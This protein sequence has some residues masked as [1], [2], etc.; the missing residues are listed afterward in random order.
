MPPMPA[1]PPVAP[2]VPGGIPPQTPPSAGGDVS[3]EERKVLLDLIAKV[4]AR[5][6]DVQANT[7]AAKASMDATRSQLL[8][9][10]FEKLQLAGIDLSSRES[11][12]AFIM[13]L[14]EQAPELAMQFEK[15]MSVL[16]GG[17]PFGEQGGADPNMPLDPNAP[18]VDPN[19]P[20]VDPN[21]PP[22]AGGAPPAAPPQP[23]PFG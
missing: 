21:A 13:N 5:I 16:L 10:V 1:M 23:M 11:V 2:P 4:K 9:Q 15:A 3:P 20:P 6:E 17:Q 8:K 12:S 19:A 14:K 22:D 18:P 7:V